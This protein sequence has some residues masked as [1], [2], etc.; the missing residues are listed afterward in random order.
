MLMGQEDHV[1]IRKKLIFDE[2]HRC[3]LSVVRD[4]A[5]EGHHLEEKAPLSCLS[6]VMKRSDGF[7]T[8]LQ[9]G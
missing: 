4:D 5:N 2:R 9:K 3:P 8:E 7:V 1:F 6:R